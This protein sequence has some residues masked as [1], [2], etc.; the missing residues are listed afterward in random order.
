MKGEVAKPQYNPST[1]DLSL[2]TS[3]V[4]VGTLIT[5]NPAVYNV[6]TVS[7]LMYR[8]FEVGI[9][10]RDTI[11]PQPSRLGSYNLYL[12]VYLSVP[13]FRTISPE[14]LDGIL[15]KLGSLIGS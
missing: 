14:L 11:I 8:Y 12:S 10:Y 6:T 3:E 7:P 4:K 9:H 15:M 1:D 5:K 13:T 2:P